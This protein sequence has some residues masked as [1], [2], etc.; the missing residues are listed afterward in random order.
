MTSSDFH[1][2]LIISHVLFF[3]SFFVFVCLLSMNYL[4][5]VCVSFCFILFPSDHCVFNICCR[6]S[7]IY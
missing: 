1:V 5:L 2:I 3:S 4:M 7:D 6:V